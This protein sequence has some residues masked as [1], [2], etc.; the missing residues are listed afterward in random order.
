MKK[1]SFFMVPKD[2]RIEKVKRNNTLYLVYLTLFYNVTNR[3][4][5]VFL[6]GEQIQLNKNEV[7]ISQSELS[8]TFNL[9]RNTLRGCLSKLIKQNI[10]EHLP[11]K[12]FNGISVY[13]LTCPKDVQNRPRTDVEQSENRTKTLSKTDRESNKWLNLQ[14]SSQVI[15]KAETVDKYVSETPKNLDNF[16]SETEERRSLG[17]NAVSPNASRAVI[18]RP[19]NNTK[20]T[21]NT[22]IN[23]SNGGSNSERESGLSASLPAPP[24]ADNFF[25][26]EIIEPSKT[27]EEPKPK[28]KKLGKRFVPS[29]RDFILAEKWR[30]YAISELPSYADRKSY[31]ADY[32]AEQISKMKRVCKIT[33]EGAEEILSWIRNDDF[34]RDKATSV[35]R[36]IEVRN[37]DR[38]LDHILKQMNRPFSQAQKA[39][40]EIEEII[41]PN[42]ENEFAEFFGV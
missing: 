22:F 4:R 6:K 28:S 33:D 23:E 35:R 29:E 27:S 36:L 25:E 34:W 41:D 32:I 40:E 11:H 15:H 14:L 9:N 19:L 5:T 39:R 1:D 37:G 24:P 16:S 21:K 12:S 38:K 26:A 13:D 3:E 10:I 30:A 7:A 8:E 18:H 31:S 2:W 42:R 20:N 17:Y